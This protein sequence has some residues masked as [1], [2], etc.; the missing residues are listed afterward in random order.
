M[1]KDSEMVVYTDIMNEPQNGDQP[2][3]PGM[4]MLEQDFSKDKVDLTAIHRYLSAKCIH[5][6]HHSATVDAHVPPEVLAAGPASGTESLLNWLG[7]DAS[8][9]DPAEF[10]AQLSRA[11]MLQEGEAVV[12]AF[13]VGRD[14]MAFTDRRVF[15]VDVQGFSGKSMLYLSI[16]YASLRGFSVASAGSWDRDA[17]VK[18]VMRSYWMPEVSMDLRKG[19]ADLAG[20]SR[21]L[22]AQLFGTYIGAGSA[23]PQAPTDA[24][25][26]VAGFLDWL[27]NDSRAVDA[28]EVDKRLH[29][30]PAILFDDEVVDTAL[31]CGRDMWVF[32]NKRVLAIDVQGLTGKRVEY[33]TV[34]LKYCI[35]CQVQS[36]GMLD[37]DAEGT[38]FVDACGARGM[39]M[40]M[41]KEKVDLFAL[42]HNLV[43]KVLS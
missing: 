41:R 25:G 9:V 8:Q 29:A 1:D 4:A 20:V 7:G 12:M 38:V 36:A 22:G 6:G 17:E 10:Q 27:G 14:T 21:F 19:K 31:K 40:E 28:Q 33:T 16:P 37:W 34:P 42:N 5:E 26:G 15:K 11:S 30:E 23:A 43:A 24:S 13:R 35:G 2:P 39:A 3:Q 18:L 32:T